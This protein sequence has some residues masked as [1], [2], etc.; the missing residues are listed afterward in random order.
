MDDL[1]TVPVEFSLGNT[2]RSLWSL[3]TLLKDSVLQIPIFQRQFIWKPKRQIP[4]WGK[5]VIDKSAIGVIVTYQTAV[6]MNQ[7]WLA[8]GFQRLTA[9]LRIAE[10]PAS[11]GFRFGAKQWQAYCEGLGITHQH[12][13]YESHNAALRAFQNLNRGTALTPAEFHKGQL[14]IYPLGAI[15]YD[16]I[17]SIVNLYEVRC[18]VNLSR[19]NRSRRGAALRDSLAL[20]YQYV[21]QTTELAFWGAASRSLTTGKSL[22]ERLAEWAHD[23]SHE[24]VDRTITNFEQFIASQEAI[25]S[26]I[27]KDLCMETRTMNQTLFRWLI[28]AGIWRKNARRPVDDY[29]DLVFK[30][31][32]HL[33]DYEV[34]PGNIVL[35][36]VEPAKIVWLRMSRLDQL[37]QICEHF[38]NN[39]YEKNHRKRQATPRGYDTSHVQPFKFFG[40][41]ETIIEPSSI[42]RARGAQPILGEGGLTE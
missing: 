10:D 15:L 42:N 38:D 29:V 32:S 34:L 5:S 11:Y 13:M 22:E 3:A 6:Q 40:E 24:I 16:R 12:R 33:R 18:H 21:T 8:D 30:L 36:D 31:M 20:F 19:T 25:I 7:L 9:T 14:V 1:F 26:K 39:L 35:P 41:G 17:P 37:S 27:K 4:E 23:Q 28:H 2:E